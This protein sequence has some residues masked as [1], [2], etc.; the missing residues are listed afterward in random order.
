[1]ATQGSTRAVVAA[2][3][4]NALVMVA[5]FVAFLFTGSG[6]MLSEAIHTLADLLNQ[7]LLLIGIV[8]S[9]R[10]PDL[11]FQYG[12]RSE[13]YVW[14][15]ISAVGIF[16][17]G[18]GVTIYHGVQS[19]IHPHELQELGWAIGVLVFALLLEGYVLLVAVRAVQKQAAGK[20]FFRY[21]RQEADPATVAVVLEDSAACFGCVIA[22][23]A[24]LL[25]KWTGSP[26]WD[27]IGSIV[28]GCLLGAI[29][30]WL[31]WRNSQL[32]IGLS[33]PPK[34]R[35]QIR[36]IIEQNP[37]VEEIVDM[38]TRVLDTETYRIKADVRFDGESLAKQLGPK[39]DQ[40][41]EQV[42]SREQFHQFA[43][44]YADDVVE[45]LAD[46]IDQIERKIQSEF[47]QAR[48]LDIEAD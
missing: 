23:V 44:E 43:R 7:I 22:M 39:I 14:A 17:L 27:A 34:I 15:L 6:A 4:G 8:R 38:K 29:A 19:L 35:Q 9:D 18:C 13:R 32:L 5:K 21:M 26:Y 24:I 40:A 48:H 47:P 2:I 16:F 41:F 12:Y 28:I 3:L 31:I 1:M 11:E 10:V 20:P 30:I 36:Q 42:Q 46:E 45:L 37:A 25:A 33:V